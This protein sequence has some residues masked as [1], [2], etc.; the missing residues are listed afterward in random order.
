MIISNLP[1]DATP[2]KSRWLSGY[3]AR[4]RRAL[5]VRGSRPGPRIARV[6]AEAAPPDKTLGQLLNL[7]EQSVDHISSLECMD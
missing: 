6:V 4:L 7:T 3:G 1:N 2:T 5:V